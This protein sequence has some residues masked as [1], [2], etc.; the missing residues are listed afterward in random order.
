MKSKDLQNIVLSKYQKG[1]V[2]T[3]ICRDLNGGISLVTAKR[4]CQM[5]RR[6]GYIELS[7]THGGPHIVRTKENICKGEKPFTP[8]NRSICSEAIDGAWYFC[9]KC[10]KNIKSRFRTEAL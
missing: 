4:W 9:N 6:A 10:Q 3:K 1:D 8:K 5:I 7:E 2:P